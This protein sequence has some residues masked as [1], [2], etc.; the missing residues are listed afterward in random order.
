MEIGQ[1]L[2]RRSHLWISL[3]LAVG[4]PIVPA[5]IEP[6]RQVAQATE[7]QQP[8]QSQKTEANQLIRQGLQQFKSKQ[9]DAARQSF[10]QA[11]AIY[12]QIKDRRGEIKALQNLGKA[13]QELSQNDKAIEV[14]QQAAQIS[15]DNNYLKPEKQVLWELVK[16]YSKQEKLTQVIEVLQQLVVNGQATTD[17]KSHTMAL[18]GLM[19]FYE[20]LKQPKK[21][22]EAYQQ[23]IALVKQHPNPTEQIEV[24]TKMVDLLQKLKHRDKVIE[25]YQQLVAIYQDQKQPKKVGMTLMEM[26]KLQLELNRYDQAKALHQQALTVFEANDDPSGQYLAFINLG[27]VYKELEQYDQAIAFYQRALTIAPDTGDASVAEATALV[28]I[29]DVYE[30]LAQYPKALE[31]YQK[32][33]KLAQVEK[34]KGIVANVL[35]KIGDIYQEQTEYTKALETY[36]QALVL[37]KELNYKSRRAVLLMQMGQVYSALGRYAEAIPQY[38]EALTLAQEAEDKVAIFMARGYLA[39][40]YRKLGQNAPSSEIFQEISRLI[41]KKDVSIEV[42][43]LEFYQTLVANAGKLA[44]PAIGNQQVNRVTE[45][46]EQSQNDLAKARKI[47]ERKDEASE[48]TDLGR[49]YYAKGQYAQALEFYQQ[50]LQIYR[51]IGN[52]AEQGNVL[53]YMGVTVARV[54]QPAQALEF[55]Q[56]ALAIHQQTG[57]RPGEAIA[58]SNIG[59]L[60]NQQNQPEL[61]IVFYKQSVNVQ[62]A[63]RAGIQKLPQDVQESYTQSVA[64]TYRALADLLITQGRVGEAQQV[65]ERLKIQEINEFTRGT[66][67]PQVIRDIELTT[68]ETEIKNKHTTLIAFGNQ[69]YEC[70]R[71]QQRC[72]QYNDL[73]TQYQSLSK[74]FLAFVDTLKQ[75]LQEDQQNSLKTATDDFQKSAQRIVQAHP[76]SILIYPLVLPDKTRILWSSKGGVFSKNAICNLG[77]AA[78]SQKVSE[79]SILLSQKGDET[80]LKTVGKELYDCLIKPLEPELT[81]NNIQHLIL[82]PDRVT[83]YIPIGALYD[84]QQYL[85]QRFATSNILAASKTDT[86]DTLPK[87]PLNT[88][89]LGFGLS[90]A[91]K[92]FSALP[93]VPKE[94]HNIIKTNPQDQTGLFP[95]Q[96]FLN[97]TFDRNAL[98]DNLSGYKILHIATH[99]EFKPSNPKSSYFLLGNGTPYAIPDIATLRHLEDIHLVVLSAC[100]TGKGGGAEIAGLSSYFIGDDSKAK[101]VLASLWKVSDSSTALLMQQFYAH[102]ANGKS[103][104]AAMQAVQQDFIAG[105]LNPIIAA[106]LPRGDFEPIVPE[107]VRS[108]S[109]QPTRYTH[110]YYWAPFILI[111]NGL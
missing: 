42:E 82:V 109:S 83:N 30:T 110:P 23:A 36:Q 3:V 29:G 12:R 104:V 21:S 31:T 53:N 103:K 89:T 111:G 16:L 7:V 24:L 1:M 64:D 8:P 79:F 68:H 58:F 95:G 94:L 66:R 97:Q 13:Y 9:F 60:L 93:N 81:A 59:Y 34:K 37:Y 41:N 108:L 73:K 20:R 4:V 90:D 65:L 86:R 45:R 102:L 18:F 47:G 50:A 32:A 100:E 48:L 54:A 55:F 106:N 85:I 2:P 5:A 78:L 75:Q 72:S 10:E 92:P 19:E 101:A 61:A 69:F 28:Q 52:K 39:L 63:I 67:S 91:Y 99:A 27:I 14:L 35:K 25:I 87:A 107:S 96:I 22:A 17:L 62:E 71:P 77:E 6:I 49:L 80:Q 26:G 70:D 88:P 76:N 46:I 38:Q 44:A 98:E 51:S 15:R 43:R 57:D 105:K 11:L 33:L 84:G 74:E 56:Q 40:A